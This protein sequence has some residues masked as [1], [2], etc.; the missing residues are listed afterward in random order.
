MNTE[1]RCRG[2]LFGLAVGDALGAAMEHAEIYAALDWPGDWKREI[3]RILE[4]EQ[5][6]NG[7]FANTASNPMTEH[8]P[9]L[10]TTLAVVALS[11]CRE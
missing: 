10:A 7:S 3:A 2:A 4:S 11:R 5:R 6:Q 1:S 8:D 9:L